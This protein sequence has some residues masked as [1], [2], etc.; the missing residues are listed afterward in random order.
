MLDLGNPK[1]TSSVMAED[2]ARRLI[3]YG[4][5]APTLSVPV[6]D[7]LMVKPTEG[8]TLF[9]LDRFIDA[10]IATR[11]EIR[12]IKSGASLRDNN[13]LKNTPHAAHNLMSEVWEHP[14]PRA[15]AAYPVT[16]LRSNDCSASVRHM[17]NVYGDCKLFCDCM[18][19]SA[20]E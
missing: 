4:F 10:M 16:A 1:G 19:V 5:H 11:G 20:T 15:L 6:P 3:G 18:A 9:D 13:P 2:V 17:D 7:T 12:Q 8:K 14:C